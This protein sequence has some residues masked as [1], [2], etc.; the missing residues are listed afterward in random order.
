LRRT[1]HQVGVDDLLVALV[2]G[3]G[4]GGVALGFLNFVLDPQAL[5]YVCY[6]L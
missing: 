6:L 5:L 4:L 2:F 1:Q 3:L